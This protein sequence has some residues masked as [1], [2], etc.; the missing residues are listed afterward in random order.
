MGYKT[1]QRTQ[2]YKF[3][4]KFPHRYFTVE[5]IRD[6]LTSEGDVISISTIYRNISRLLEAGIIKKNVAMDGREAS[7]RYIDDRHCRNE[8]HVKCTICG[9]I[10]HADHILS[11]LLRQKLLEKNAFFLDL[12]KTVLYGICED[13]C[14]KRTSEELAHI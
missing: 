4:K 14:K 8:I 12:N 5:E 3:L 9:K 10:F 7:F 11:E 6:E 2:L 13:C 1:E